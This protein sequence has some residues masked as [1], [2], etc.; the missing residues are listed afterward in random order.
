MVKPSPN[1]ATAVWRSSPAGTSI[2]ASTAATTDLGV[3][4]EVDGPA[5]DGL[6]DPLSRSTPGPTDAHLAAERVAR[7][8]GRLSRRRSRRASPCRIAVSTKMRS[9]SSMSTST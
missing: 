7:H 2:S 9:V 8:V 6:A 5:G 3:S 4:A 1:T